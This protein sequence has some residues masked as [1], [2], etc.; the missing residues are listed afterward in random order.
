MGYL[1]CYSWSTSVHFY[2][3]VP[4]F[5]HQAIADWCF[6]IF[7]LCHYLILDSIYVK[8]LRGNKCLVKSLLATWHLW[9]EKR[10]FCWIISLGPNKEH[11]LYPPFFPSKSFACRLLAFIPHIPTKAEKVSTVLNWTFGFHTALRVNK[12]QCVWSIN[13]LKSF[14]EWGRYIVRNSH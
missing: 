9:R 14:Y 12:D 5:Y 6:S 3:D 4:S 1:E 7:D 11:V 13:S 10:S 2:C 8:S